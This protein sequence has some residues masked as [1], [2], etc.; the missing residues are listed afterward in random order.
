M[1]LVN[2]QDGSVVSRTLLNKSMVNVTMF[3][4]DKDESLSEHTSPHDALAISLEGEIE[5]SIGNEVHRL[6]TGDILHMPAEEPH[7]LHAIERCKLLLI[8]MHD[9]HAGMR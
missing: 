2:Y 5:I 6:G 7:A 9:A 4:F 8:L 3:A 1:D